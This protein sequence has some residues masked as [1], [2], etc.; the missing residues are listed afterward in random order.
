MI[1]ARVAALD[2]SAVERELD[3]G[4]VA[5]AGNLLRAEECTALAQLYDVEKTFRSRV[6][7][8]RHGF[9][10]GEYRYFSYP[11]PDIIQS[12]RTLLFRRLAALANRWNE[13]MGLEARYPADLAAFL[14]RCHA[15]GQRQPTPLLLQY[16]AGDFNCLHQ[17]V[18]GEHVFP[19]QAAILLSEPGRDFQGGEFVVT[20]QRP[21]MQSRVEVLHLRQGDLAIFAVRDRPVKGARGIHRVK[22]RHGVSRVHSGRRHM[23]GVVFHDAG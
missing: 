19:L 14:L 3:A 22:H 17:D 7:M 8:A 21:R 16:A 1:D 10:R 18:Y 9:G 12:L 15:A 13:L 4:G 20:E 6:I 23:L 5:R 2:W 11:L